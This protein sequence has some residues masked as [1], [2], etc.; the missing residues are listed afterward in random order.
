MDVGA[1]GRKERMSHW[2]DWRVSVLADLRGSI[3]QRAACL[4]LLES[5]IARLSLPT[6]AVMVHYV[7]SWWSLT[8]RDFA[9]DRYSAKSYE[10]AR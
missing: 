3:G 9:G 8:I 1:G 5:R 6:P 4:A 7:L 10:N 2:T